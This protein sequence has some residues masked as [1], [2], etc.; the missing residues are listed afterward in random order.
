MRPKIRFFTPRDFLLQLHRDLFKIENHCPP[1]FYFEKLSEFEIFILILEDRRFFRHFG[2][3]LRSCFREFFRLATFR[4]HGGASTIDMQFVRTV[5]GYKERTLKRKLYEM[6]LAITIQS[7]Y[8]KLEIL[9]AYLNCAF[10]GSHLIGA[11]SASRAIFGKRADELDFNDASFLA[12]TLVYPKP[13]RPTDSW[14][15]KVERRAK[16]ARSLHPLLK[17]RFEQLPR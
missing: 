2:I 13:L 11:D 16:Y 12:A 5:T 3:D 17:K 14:I 10:F 7:K 1:D 4:N 15:R 9:H 8:T 6:L